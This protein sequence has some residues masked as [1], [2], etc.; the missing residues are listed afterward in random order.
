[1]T[2]PEDTSRRLPP[3]SVRFHP[4]VLLGTAGWAG[5]CPLMPG[6]VGS[7]VPGLPLAWLCVREGQAVT[8]LTAGALLVLGLWA[9]GAC[10]KLLGREDPPA[11]VID[12][13]LGMVVATWGVTP[14][15][16]GLLG[17][18]LLFRL[19]D[20]W[21]PWPVRWLDRKVPGGAGIMADDL[22]AGLLARAVLEALLRILPF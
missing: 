15:W 20:I 1:M 4:A 19:F 18:F 13:V 17:G 10:E 11:V 5:F 8:A 14:G 7:L 22:A 21:K 12:E 6:T 2:N 16:P 3:W 9:A